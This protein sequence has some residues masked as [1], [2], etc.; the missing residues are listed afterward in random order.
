ML[1]RF[2]WRASCARLALTALVAGAALI[3]ATGASAG[4]GTSTTVPFPFEGENPCIPGEFL[5]GMG[6]LHL[7]ITDNL[8]DSGNIQF[9]LEANVSGL[10]AVTTPPTAGKKYVVIDQSGITQTFAAAAH[11]TVEQTFQL[12]RSGEDGTL[13]QGDD[14][15]FHYLAHITANANGD[16][17]VQDI[18]TDMRCK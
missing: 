10:Q 15:Y 3:A 6:T 14:F 18:N 4:P 2:L 11:E 9:H 12:V 8:S 17:T 13:L 7:L 1:A 5:T 16:I